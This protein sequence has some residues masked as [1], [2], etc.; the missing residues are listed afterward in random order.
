M[1]RLRL[2][3]EQDAAVL[4]GIYRPYVLETAVTFETEVPA[5]AE[6]ARHIRD[7]SERFPYLVAEEAGQVLGYAYAHPFHTRAAYQWTAETS[8]YLRQ[9]VRGRGVGKMLYTALL[10]LLAHQGI[11]RA[12][13]VV[14]LPGEQSVGF[15][16]ALG[17]TLT[18]HLPG[19]GY[20]CGRWWD[21][22]YLS[23]ALGEEGP[24]GEVTPFPALLRESGQN[25]A[26]YC[27]GFLANPGET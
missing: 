3:R 6:F 7:V 8:I 15:H 20:K 16:R 18:G 25:P 12:V 21:M 9:D 17:F 10:K 23:L 14:T 4:L 26:D 22:G 19:A 13:A 5:E 24:P 11:R 1:I 27:K 2:A